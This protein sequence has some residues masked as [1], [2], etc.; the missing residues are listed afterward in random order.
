MTKRLKNHLVPRS[1][2]IQ[3]QCFLSF[4]TTKNHAL[5][6]ELPAISQNAGSWRILKCPNHN[7]TGHQQVV[8]M[9]PPAPLR[10]HNNRS[11][12]NDQLGSESPFRISISCYF[13]AS[14]IRHRASQPIPIQN[15]KAYSNQKWYFNLC[16]NPPSLI[17]CLQHA[18]KPATIAVVK[19][20]ITGV[21]ETMGL[22]RL[23]P[24]S[25]ATPCDITL[26]TN[27]LR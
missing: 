15:A 20:E 21:T 7:K 11:T 4:V 13:T 26:L 23:S 9:F 1:H 5:L 12:S 16:S 19:W 8:H 17:C 27:L 25:F 10:A 2:I 6:R 22:F 24:F 14:L 18:F 3:M